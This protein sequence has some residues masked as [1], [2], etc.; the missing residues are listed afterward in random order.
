MSTLVTL[1]STIRSQ[2]VSVLCRQFAT[3]T[4][5]EVPRITTPHKLK[6]Q[7]Q[8]KERNILRKKAI[9]A[10]INMT[11]KRSALV[12]SCKRVQYNHHQGQTYSEFNPSKLASH[13]W[14]NYK[15]IGD[16]FTIKANSKNPAL[17][18]INETVRTFEDFDLNEKLLEQIEEL[19]FEY[20]TKIQRRTF[21]AVLQGQNV[22]CAAETGSG[23]T[24]AYLLPIME[25]LWRMQANETAEDTPPNSP[26]AI[27]ILPSQELATQVAEVA[28]KFTKSCGIKLQLLSGKGIPTQNI[29]FFG[30]ET[31]DIVVSTPMTLL[32]FFYSGKLTGARCQHLVLD[33]ADTLLD[34]S[35][36]DVIKKI[37]QKLQIIVPSASSALTTDD[38]PYVMSGTQLLL[39]SATMPR[40]LD[41]ILEDFI[42]IESFQRIKT[43]SLHR[44]L[45][46]VPHTFM[47]LHHEQKADEILR[48]AKESLAN[49]IPTM[50][51]CNKSDTCFWVHKLLKEH[52]IHN[53]VLNAQMDRKL[54]SGKFA[55]FQNEAADIFVCTDICSRG[56]DTLRVQL[57]INFDLPSYVSDYIHRSGRVGR[58][59]S[60]DG[61]RVVSFA[62]QKW[63]V[64]LIWN[65]ETA[66]RKSAELENVNANIKRKITS[67]V[68]KKF[69]KPS[70]K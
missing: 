54:R 15:S 3:R 31:I 57:V 49:S 21:S 44:L 52:G 11:N 61:G 9:Q 56:L 46:H 65:I 8:K 58:V 63:D 48:L 7:F 50:I 55:N 13:G 16:H 69:R 20:P 40:S 4:N 45:P 62:T 30:K 59:G 1:N 26:R 70:E 29:R 24:L 17:Q 2:L 38:Q 28:N 32:K 19:N 39:I 37:M 33:E 41:S 67:I 42:E 43:E 36:S 12:I 68:Q 25:L 47:R 27:I 34:D 5:V 14:S 22:I 18:T 66:A 10:K 53:I 60:K 6:V 64:K 23:K 35:F 51:F